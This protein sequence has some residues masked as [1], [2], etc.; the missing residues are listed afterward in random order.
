MSRAL[1]VATAIATIVL[2]VTALAAF[3][4]LGAS[5]AVVGRRPG[6]HVIGDR[7]VGESGAVQLRGV[8][9]MGFEYSCVQGKG[10]FDAPLDQ[11][12]VDAIRSWGVNAVRLP[13][14]EHCWLGI[15]GS[16][17]GDAYR[18]GVREYVGRLVQSGLYVILD[19]HWSASGSDMANEQQP[20]PN[21]EHSADFWRSV[22]HV[23]KDDER[24]LFDLFNEPVPNSNERDN[25][26]DA[27]R[28]SWECW[29]RGAAGGACDAAQLHGMRGDDVAGMQ[30][31]VDAVRGTGA[32]NVILVAGIQWGNTLWSSGSR[33]WLV[34]RPVDPLR[35]LAASWHVYNRTWC[36][37]VACFETE[38]APIAAQAPVVV[39]EFGDETCDP[40]W[41][42][43]LLDWLDRKQ[44]G[45]LAWVW[46]TWMAA[47]CSAK[48]LITEY[49]GTPSEYGAFY[50][51]RLSRA[52]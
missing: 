4:D 11:A 44:L 12:S 6:L 42:N 22:A 19:L 46:N 1:F 41:M 3:V 14:N 16:P 48:H 39:A 52:P 45:Y 15:A 49:D 29:L 9:R 38:V 10:L 25:T 24:V 26:D 18:Q 21:V 51:Q 43:G 20:M 13:L 50:R 36:I 40:T 33:N 28:R 5:E 2:A 30:S 7:L 8:N 27:A 17:S 32:T 37:T 35:N 34:Y 47:D 31:L 23:F